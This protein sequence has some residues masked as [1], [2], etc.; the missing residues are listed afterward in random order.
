[1]EEAVEL[2]IISNNTPEIF[3]EAA[4]YVQNKTLTL[5]SARNFAYLKVNDKLIFVE[6]ELAVKN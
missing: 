6:V 4:H 5:E 2:G 1:L 3:R